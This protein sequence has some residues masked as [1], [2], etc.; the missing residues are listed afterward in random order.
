M[1]ELNDWIL[2]SAL[3]FGVLL[4]IALILTFVV[5]KKKK[6]DKLSE[7]NYQIFFNI[8]VIWIPVGVVFMVAIN[9]AIGIAFMGMGVAYV[10][11]GLANR[12]KWEKK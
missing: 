2:I 9:P 3:I 5:L 4:I 10:A 1:I 8:G 12:D 11:I 6:E 7:T